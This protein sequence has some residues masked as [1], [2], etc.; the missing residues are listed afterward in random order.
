MYQGFSRPRTAQSLSSPLPVQ[1]NNPRGVDWFRS[2][3]RQDLASC[4]VPAEHPDWVRVCSRLRT[5]GSAPQ[6]PPCGE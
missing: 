4:R 2:P 5:R 1:R 3:H 6:D